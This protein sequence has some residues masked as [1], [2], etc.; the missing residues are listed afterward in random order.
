MRKAQHIVNSS[1]H[2]DTGEFI[3]R[4]M[5]MCGY[6]PMSIPTLFGFLLSKPTTFNIIF[7]QWA[8]QT[9]SAGVNYANRNASSS[10]TPSGIAAVYSAAVVSSI[11]VGLGMR[12]ILNPFS[13]N[14]K[15]PKALFMNFLISFFAVGGA[16]LA[17]LCMM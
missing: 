10:L 16:N 13:A 3:P 4:L 8:N 7:W 11:G 15:G 5:R 17:N 2:P 9:Y 1:V 6:A 14:F 12:K